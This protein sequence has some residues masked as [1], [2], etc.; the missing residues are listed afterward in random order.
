MTYKKRTG[1]LTTGKIRLRNIK[2]IRKKKQ[3]PKT[4]S[5]RVITNVV[6]LCTVFYVSNGSHQ[7]YIFTVDLAIFCHDYIE[8]N[9]KSIEYGIRN[10]N[11][12]FRHLYYIQ[13]FYETIKF[14]YSVHLYR[15]RLNNNNFTTWN[16]QDSFLVL[17]NFLQDY[18]LSGLSEYLL[19]T[20][21]IG[22]SSFKCIN[23]YL[24]MEFILT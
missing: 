23:V 3:L 9:I 11:I 17:S 7:R 24:F 6:I 19:S 8:N 15:Y 1:K 16:T 2:T 14:R 21:P 12:I 5:I 22:L 20:G 13:Y 10:K 4:I 18:S